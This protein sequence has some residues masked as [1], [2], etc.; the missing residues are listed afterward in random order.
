MHLVINLLTYNKQFM[1]SY[2][3]LLYVYLELLLFILKKLN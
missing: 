2:F 3:C 1:F